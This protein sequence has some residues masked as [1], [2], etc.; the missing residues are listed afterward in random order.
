MNRK[1]LLWAPFVL[2]VALFGAFF[3][4]LRNPDD[5]VIASQ[6]V[7][8]PL[9]EFSAAAVMPGQPGTASSDYRDGKPRMI[10]I[11]ASWCVPC[12]A[13]APM[14]A[15]LK[16]AGAQIDGI[17]VHDAPEPL[18]KFLAQNGNP[19]SRIGLDPEGRA[20]IAFG[21]AGVPET[22]VVDGQ[23]KII[24]QHIGIVEPKDV[25]M[26]LNLLGIKP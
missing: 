24:Y 8:K 26:L 25:P 12:A 18:A 6:M 4:G 19:F 5:R 13:E 11:F 21:S 17:A 10:N 23:G 22:F 3:V 7:G 9:P 2:V 20:Q 16:A 14:L 1:V 15:Q